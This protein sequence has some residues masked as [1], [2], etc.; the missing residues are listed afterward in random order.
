[1]SDFLPKAFCPCRQPHSPNCKAWVRFLSFVAI[2]SSSAHV[3][4]RQ[5]VWKR[6]LFK[7]KGTCLGGGHV[8]EWRSCSRIS[9]GSKWRQ[10]WLSPPEV[11][12]LR[13]TGGQQPALPGPQQQLA[14][15]MSRRSF[16]SK[17]VQGE[18]SLSEIPCPTAAQPV[19]RAKIFLWILNNSLCLCVVGAE[20]SNSETGILYWK[21]IQ[22]LLLIMC[23][24]ESSPPQ[25]SNRTEP[26]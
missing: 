20:R 14:S 6:S 23:Y 10:K 4:A 1:M 11:L 25:I 19:F 18:V 3:C 7:Q 8:P 24:E 15:E 17:R 13:T 22:I 16:Q 26:K 21:W 2:L 5:W 9:S 12:C